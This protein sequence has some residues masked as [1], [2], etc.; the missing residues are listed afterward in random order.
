MWLQGEPLGGGLD[1]LTFAS[2]SAVRS[3]LGR[4]GPDAPRKLQ[5]ARIAV[6]GPVTASAVQAEG[7]RVDAIA[8]EASDAGLVRAI[9]SCL[10]EAEGGGES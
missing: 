8:E 2:P 4:L 3:L 6:I 7:L 1:V 5:R 10:Q 9:V